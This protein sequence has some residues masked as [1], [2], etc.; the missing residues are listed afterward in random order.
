MEVIVWVLALLVPAGASIAVLVLVLADARAD[1]VVDAM[2]RLPS[3]PEAPDTMAEK[4]RAR[5][6][7]PAA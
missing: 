6:E 1:A 3:S 4:A 2:R 7:R 5:H